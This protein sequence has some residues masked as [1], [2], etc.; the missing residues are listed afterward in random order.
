MPANATARGASSTATCPSSHS[1]AAITRRQALQVTAVRTGQGSPA[2]V[3]R[4][5]V[6]G[7]GR[8]GPVVPA[9]SSTSPP[10]SWPFVPDARES[11]TRA[12]N[13]R[14]AFVLPTSGKAFNVP[15]GEPT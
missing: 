11:D 12:M 4:G 1:P 5:P 15:K 13:A 10:R 8:V 3:C 2:Q 6:V 14:P 9:S 7:A